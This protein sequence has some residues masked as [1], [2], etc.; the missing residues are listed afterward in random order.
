MAYQNTLHILFRL[1]VV[2]LFFLQFTKNYKIYSISSRQ[3]EN[4]DKRNTNC[5]IAM[6]EYYAIYC[7]DGY[8]AVFNQESLTVKYSNQSIKP[9][10]TFDSTQVNSS[11]PVLDIESRQAMTITQPNTITV[12]SDKQYKVSLNQLINQL[13]PSGTPSSNS[14]NNSNNQS[15]K[16]QFQSAYYENEMLHVQAYFPDIS[17]SK[18]ATFRVNN[19]D[20]FND[21]TMLYNLSSNISVYTDLSS[22]QNQFTYFLQKPVS[23]DPQSP[24]S[25]RIIEEK[26][27]VSS[28]QANVQ[29]SIA[30]YAN[31]ATYFKATQLFL[32][33]S[34]PSYNNDQ[35]IIYIFLR[36]S[37]TP[38]FEIRG[39]QRGAQFGEQLQVIDSPDGLQLQIFSVKQLP[40]FSISYIEIIYNPSL[41]PKNQQISL[42]TILIDSFM[43]ANNSG[44]LNIASYDDN[45][46]M[47]FSKFD[48]IYG[49][50]ACNYQSYYSPQLNQC[51]PCNPNEY[52]VGDFNC[53]SCSNE[54]SVPD[55]YSKKFSYICYIY[56][57]NKY[58]P[59]ILVFAVFGGVL[60]TLLVCICLIILRIKGYI[61]RASY[62]RQQQAIHIQR[63]ERNEQELSRLVV[64]FEKYYPVTNYSNIINK[65]NQTDCV[66]CFEEYKPEAQVRQ[67]RC[68]HI[69]HDQC[70]MEW[71][72]NK[73]DK[74]D[75][76]TCRQDLSP[77]PQNEP[78]ANQPQLQILQG[79]QFLQIQAPPRNSVLDQ[80]NPNDSSSDLSNIRQPQSDN[81]INQNENVD[82]DALNQ[83]NQASQNTEMRVE[84]FR[85][86]PNLRNGGSDNSSNLRNS[87]G[88]AR[89]NRNAAVNAQ[90]NSGNIV[91]RSSDQLGARA[92][93]RNSN[94]IPQVNTD[95][96]HINTQLPIVISDELQ[97]Q[98]HQRNNNIIPSVD[99]NQAHANARPTVISDEL[100]QQLQL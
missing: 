60:I 67:M 52:Q 63:Q 59:F 55:T 8:T 98:P 87:Q 65:G 33:V 15:T 19:K 34:C 45:F 61:C 30:Q 99:T 54:E 76:P 40:V 94:I 58:N 95:Q 73:I 1:F 90:R 12:I 22:G 79:P 35:G 16:V 91:P 47:M 25:P 29:I 13:N 42:D 7:K 23:A 50:T 83:Q 10:Y 56:N 88:G 3:I 78:I 27:D 11:Q 82:Q 64:A 74:P 100:Q 20:Q 36:A 86:Q 97:Q 43:N 69:F 6:G 18:F 68:N 17:S 24:I 21:F 2:T 49:I 4:L 31:C 85:T 37:L 66:I 26:V 5:M 70:I 39:A 53:Y 84:S 44:K 9:K 71:I 80:S 93:Q 81:P 14:S 77:N 32:I 96:S 38:I 48:T 41:D 89:S 28:F 62:L 92:H 51:L 72:K 46:M 57:D 75:C